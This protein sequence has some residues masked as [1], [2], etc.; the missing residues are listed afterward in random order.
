MS[1]GAIPHIHP[2]TNISKAYYKH[3]V[4][5]I[6]HEPLI[7]HTTLSVACFVAA[8]VVLLGGL[9]WFAKSN[10]GNLIQTNAVVTGISSGKTDAI[11]TVTTFITFEFGECDMPDNTP[12]PCSVRQPALEGMSYTVGQN[13]KVGYHPKNHHYARL[14][15]DNRP[16]KAAIALWT[17]PFIIMIWLTFVAL[18]RHHARQVEIWNAAEAADTDD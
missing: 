2:K 9:I 3:L 8:I 15:N 7:K 16:P 14:F 13:I 11:G 18:F 10:P 12:K 17:V 1:T 6:E 4:D 5:S